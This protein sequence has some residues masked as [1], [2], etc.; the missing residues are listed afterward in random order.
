MLHERFSD[1]IIRLASL[2]GGSKSELDRC[3]R[4]G[5]LTQQEAAIVEYYVLVEKIKNKLDVVGKK[6][7]KL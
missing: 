5:E 6:A 7:D 2:N 1:L 3:V 4:A